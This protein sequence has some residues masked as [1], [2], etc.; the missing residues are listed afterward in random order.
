[1]VTFTINGKTVD[2][3]DNSTILEA[4]RYNQIKIPSLCY[5][6]QDHAI[7]ACRICV[8]EVEGAKT[9]QASCVTK[10]TPGMVIHT[11]SR[12]V[13]HARRLLYELILSDHRQN[14]LSCSRNQNCEL[15]TLGKMLGV[16]DA[17]FEGEHSTERIDASYSITRDMGK[18]ILCRR[19]VT[20]CN[21]VQSVGILKAQNRGYNT[22]ISPAFGLPIGTVNCSFCGQCTVV[23]P[24]GALKETPSVQRVWDALNAPKKRVAVQVAPAIRVAIGEEF[25][26]PAGTSCTGKLATALKELGFDDVFD[27]NWAADLTIMEEGTELLNRLKKA[28]GGGKSALPMITS[29]SPGWIKFVEHTFPAELEHLSTCKSPHTMMGA[30]LKSYYAERELGIDPA[31]LFVVSVMPCTAKKSEIVREEMQNDGHPNVDAVLTCRELAEMIRTAGINFQDL[32]D[33]KFREPMGRSSGAADIFGLTGGVMEAA[34][35][36]VYEVVTGRELPFENLHVTPIVGL[37]GVKEAAIKIEGALED[38]R[39]LEGV[40]LRVAVA[41]GL[42]NARRLMEEV[43]EGKSP[44]QFIEIMGCPGGCILGGGQPRSQ[45]PE[46]GQKR[47]EGLYREDEGKKLRKSH[48][49][50]SIQTLYKSYLGEPNGYLAHKLLHTQYRRRGLYNQYSGESFAVE[51]P[52]PARPELFQAR[53][54]ELGRVQPERRREEPESVRVMALQAENDRLKKELSDTQETVQIFK[55]VISDYTDREQPPAQP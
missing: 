15:Q 27:T 18:C 20:V 16:E 13:Q 30:V 28:F 4:A 29:C 23:C 43:A 49:N 53:T 11:N 24:V 10:V 50:P 44:Y 54:P 1:M 7:G 38:Y 8:V 21:Q 25:G 52:Q 46:V 32:Q 12:R 36:T 39:C 47:L 6:N 55:M 48:E 9:L 3:P 41:S 40:E 17:R 35:R 31:D 5:L 19:C 14:C 37:E 22:E 2:A 51:V 45:D 26:M 34:L 33:S 42:K